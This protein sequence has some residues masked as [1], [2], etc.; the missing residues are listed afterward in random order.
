VGV[1]V[2]ILGALNIAVGVV[3]VAAAVVAGITM[4]VLRARAGETVAR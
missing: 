3:G 4:L 1:L 2:G